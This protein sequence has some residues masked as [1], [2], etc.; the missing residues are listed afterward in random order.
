M[1]EGRA[2]VALLSRAIR[3]RGQ[4]RRPHVATGRLRLLCPL[5]LS[6]RENKTVTTDRMATKS[7]RRASGLHRRQIDAEEQHPLGI[8]ALL[9]RVEVGPLALGA[10]DLDALVAVFDEIPGD[11]AFPLAVDAGLD[12]GADGG[13]RELVA[14]PLGRGVG[15]LLLIPAVLRPILPRPD[16][17]IAVAGVWAALHR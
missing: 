12:L 4:R 8:A 17:E 15:G 14:A 5:V 1:L 11:D 6:F 9:C 10:I 16:V 3:G 7:G 2:K 13:D